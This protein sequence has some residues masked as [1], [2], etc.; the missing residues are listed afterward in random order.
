MMMSGLRTFALAFLLGGWSAVAAGAEPAPSLASL[1]SDLVQLTLRQAEIFFVERNRELQAGQR[2]V[3]GAEADRISA[4]QRPN[5]NLSFSAS[6]LNP[7]SGLGSGDLRDKQ[8]GS[9]LSV[10]QLFERGNKRELRM[11][12]ADQNI[13]ASR[14]EYADIQRQ[15]KVA[16]YSA[17]YDLVAAQ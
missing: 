16:L 12:A 5:P 11:D 6:P 9:I 10:Q 3:E 7:H 4:A 2:L 8:V 17:Y 15:Q 1:N 14:G 13:R